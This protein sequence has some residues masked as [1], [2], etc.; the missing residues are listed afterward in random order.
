MGIAFRFFTF[1]FVVSFLSFSSDAAMPTE[2]KDWFP[3]EQRV[4]IRS[5]FKNISRT[6]AAPGCVVASP[7]KNN[8]NYFYHWV[9]DAALTMNVVLEFYKKT[10]YP[11]SKEAAMKRLLEYA[12]FSRT[13]QLTNN[14]SGNSDDL[15][16]FGEPKFLA[17]GGKFDGDWARPQSD[18]PALRA[19]TLINLAR[20]LI[21]NGQEMY[22]RENLYD[23]LVPSNTVIKADLQ[24]VGT[25]WRAKTND[26]WEEVNGDQ[27]YTRMVQRKALIEGARFADE[28]RDGEAAKWY[29]GQAQAITAEIG[30]HWNPANG[31]I[32][33]TI[34]QVGGL[35]T[36]TSGLDTAVILAVLHGD[37]GDGFF[38]PTDERVLSTAYQLKREFIKNYAIN[39]DEKI[40]GIAIGRYPEDT[41]D[42]TDADFVNGRQRET[43]G[44]P[45]FL[46]TL[47]FAEL[48]YKAETDFRNAGQI[49]ITPY[50]LAFFQDLLPSDQFDPGM[51][52]SAGEEFFNRVVQA[53]RISGDGYLLRVA[54]HL[55]RETGA[56]SEQFN[57]QTGIMQSATDLTWSYAAFL[58]AAWARPTVNDYLYQL[59]R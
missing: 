15:S 48:L 30:R 55:N 7:S 27:F 57:R 13:N 11:E 29:R 21:Q 36:K 20:I 19:I 26:L 18:G 45:W 16:G 6:D 17:D 28:M 54:Y 5:M 56:M 35:R 39:H 1:I 33:A 37:D 22:V 52:I 24:Y 43:F 53:L 41:Y 14:R 8:P 2:F 32:Y 4:S 44:N 38:G 51:V 3:A 59:T 47:A 50:N 12:A 10:L 25:Y 58:T 49:K 46:T 23:G 40:P 31:R 9:R 42:G 34:N